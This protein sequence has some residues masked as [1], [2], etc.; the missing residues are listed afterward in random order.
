M[1][2]TTCTMYMAGGGGGGHAANSSHISG[3]RVTVCNPSSSIF[4]KLAHKAGQLV[5]QDNTIRAWGERVEEGKARERKF[6]GLEV[7]YV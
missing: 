5:Q 1:Y 3:T 6:A 2:S 4:L 7:Q